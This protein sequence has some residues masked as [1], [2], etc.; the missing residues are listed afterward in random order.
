MELYA[1]SPHRGLLALLWVDRRDSVIYPVIR[2]MLNI[3]VPQCI[4]GLQARFCYIFYSNKGYAEYCSPAMHGWAT[5][6]I[7]FFT[8]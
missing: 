4:A 6:R 8:E 1:R 3:V 2:D 7:L 5:D